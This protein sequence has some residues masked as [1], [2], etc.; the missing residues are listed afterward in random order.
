VISADVLN[1]GHALS[2]ASQ[3]AIA[4][5]HRLIRDTS[6]TFTFVIG[7]G[8]SI[9][10]GLPSWAELVKGLVERI[11][12]AFRSLAITDADDPM[13]KAEYVLRM[14]VK[15]KGGEEEHH[16]QSALYKRV[17]KVVPGQ[18]TLSLADLITQLGDRASVI[19]TNFDEAIEAAFAD[20]GVKYEQFTL[21]HRDGW[22]N[23]IGNASDSLPIMHLHGIVP[24]EGSCTGPVILTESHFLKHGPRAR[25]VVRN[26]LLRSIVVFVGVSLTDPNLV[27][28]LWDTRKGNSRKPA[29][30][31]T[32]PTPIGRE[33]LRLARSYA[34]RKS[35][36][37]EVSLGLRVVVMKSFGQLE[38]LVRELVISRAK[39][40]LYDETDPDTSLHYGR[41]FR[42]VIRECHMSLGAV[43]PNLE[44]PTQSR[45]NL[46]NQLR[47]SLS[48]GKLA[49]GIR[50]LRRDR[51]TR[52]RHD[53]L[54]K[55]CGDVSL[56]P[57]RFGIS[58]WL[59]APG[60]TERE[61]YSIG[62]MA[63]S[64]MI[65]VEAPYLSQVPIT[66]GSPVL[67]ARCMFR[68][69]SFY[70]ELPR[71]DIYGGWHSG[72]AVPLRV[73]GS[74]GVYDWHLTVG[75]VCL[76]SDLHCVTPAN[77]RASNGKRVSVMSALDDDQ[78]KKLADLLEVTARQLLG[79]T[80]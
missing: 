4:D 56:S 78:K 31:L 5:L 60:D 17:T 46:A 42:R 75:A 6:E 74:I 48:T 28:P 38:Q 50:D 24:R 72:V 53:K 61:I 79:V 19:T 8:A 29:F 1:D 30:A 2:F 43:G 3:P 10:S 12:P 59:R 65:P 80:C 62:M 64:S 22:D 9:D 39:P 49:E 57:E 47:D 77:V 36:Y 67:E 76:T 40:I 73:M 13:R 18:L 16:I 45:L 33:D 26:A 66:P 41:R 23:R 68:G 55:Q 44:L 27:G 11:D 52:E 14:A 54:R 21:S 51:K 63:S 71:T 7:A 70:S 25:E 37:L 69:M 20:G 58:L 32:V 34:L 15:H 35:E